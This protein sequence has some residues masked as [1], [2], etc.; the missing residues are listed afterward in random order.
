MKKA[1]TKKI[2][3]K[4]MEPFFWYIYGIHFKGSIRKIGD[5]GKQGN[6]EGWGR[7]GYGEIWAQ[8]GH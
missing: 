1:K 7:R 5:N 6:W 8:P 2:S 3:R 4:K